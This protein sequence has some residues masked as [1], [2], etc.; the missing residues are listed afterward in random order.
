M[1]KNGDKIW[2]D[3]QGNYMEAQVMEIHNVVLFFLLDGE[4]S[5]CLALTNFVPI[6]MSQIWVKKANGLVQDR[7]ASHWLN[8]TLA[9]QIWYG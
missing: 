8:Q 3:A 1:N 2:K 9:K 7:A 5:I 6:L 4:W